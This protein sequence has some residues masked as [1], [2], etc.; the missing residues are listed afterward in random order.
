M[1]LATGHKRSHKAGNIPF[2]PFDLHEITQNGMG[3]AY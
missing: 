1:A 3:N 2:M